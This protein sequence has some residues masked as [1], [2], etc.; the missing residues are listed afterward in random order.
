VPKKLVLIKNDVSD[1]IEHTQKR[2]SMDQVMVKNYIGLFL[3]KLMDTY[4]K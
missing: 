2:E 4:Q 1:C 3:N